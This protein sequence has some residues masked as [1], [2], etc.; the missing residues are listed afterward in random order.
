MGT[1]KLLL[2]L[3]AAIILIANGM[4]EIDDINEI[5]EIASD[6]VVCMLR[7]LGRADECNRCLK[8]DECVFKD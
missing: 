2:R 6:N 3:A 5:P 4:D 7:F 8:D 1:R